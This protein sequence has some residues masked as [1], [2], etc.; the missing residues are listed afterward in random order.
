RKLLAGTCVSVVDEHVEPCGVKRSRQGFRLL[1]ESGKRDDV[2]VVRRHGGWPLDASLVVVL[3]D[4]RSHRACRTDA[5]TTH[6][7]RLLLPVLVQK[8]GAEGLRI[9]RAELED[10]TELD[11]RLR[12]ELAAAF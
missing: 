12:A 3:F 1:G 6:H 7:D 4:D 10:V 5:V 9:E 8:R 11:R 2:D